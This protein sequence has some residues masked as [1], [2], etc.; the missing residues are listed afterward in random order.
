MSETIRGKDSYTIT[1]KWAESAGGQTTVGKSRSG[2]MV[3]IKKYTSIKRPVHGSDITEADYAKRVSRF[4]KFVQGRKEI[5]EKLRMVYASGGN[6]LVPFEEFVYENLFYEV[7]EYIERIFADPYEVAALPY[8]DRILLLKTAVA[9]LGTIHTRL[10]IIHCDLKSGNLMAARTSDGYVVGKLIDFDCSLC[11]DKPLPEETGGDQNYMSPELML[12]SMSEGDPEYA[13]NVTYKTD[14]FS[15]GLVFHFYLSGELPKYDG[16]TDEKL[17]KKIDKGI[18]VYPCQV[19]QSGGKL[20]ISDR[21]DDPLFTNIIQEMLDRDPAK[22]P[23][24]QEILERLKG[25]SLIKDFI[26]A[27]WPEHGIK[28]NEEKL[29]KDGYTGVRKPVS[30]S[31]GKYELLISGTIKKKLTVDDLIHLGYADTLT[32]D[33]AVIDFDDPWPEDLLSWNIDILTSKR[34]SGI[35][36]TSNG[37]YALIRSGKAVKE[38]NA[39]ELVK[40]K[41]ASALTKPYDDTLAEPWPEDHIMLDMER[42]KARRYVAIQRILHEG[43]KKY[44]LKSSSGKTKV[45]STAELVNLKYAKMLD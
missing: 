13:K 38:Y 3:F 21:I 26:E 10:N 45:L 2:K 40:L 39:K 41:Y 14:I 9:A 17:K 8:E 22:R 1:A 6:I 11:A 35:K 12:Y 44:E 25:K 4:D 37:R 24:C 28:L 5:N 34:Y 16:I 42:I 29:R 15:L 36:R 19:V 18:R 20:V 23:D 7:S 32:S 31:R 27:P 30:S 43:E 33:S